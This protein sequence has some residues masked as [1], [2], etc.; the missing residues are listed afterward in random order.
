MSDL[1]VTPSGNGADLSWMRRVHRPDEMLHAPTQ[2]IETRNKQGQVLVR[3]PHGLCVRGDAACAARGAL[4]GVPGGATA[5]V[6]TWAVQTFFHTPGLKPLAPMS[7]DGFERWV[8]EA[9]APKIELCG[10]CGG[11]GVEPDA[12]PD[13]DGLIAACS[14]CHGE[15]RRVDEH[16]VAETV[17]PLRVVVADLRPFLAHL[18]PGADVG[19][20]YAPRVNIPGAL[21][22]H[23]RAMDLATRK[24]GAWRLCLMALDG[25]V[26]MSAGCG[27]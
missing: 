5:E 15:P 10:R 19:V 25:G 11:T 13:E 14:R 17:G 6:A 21:D 20:L 26:E 1:I 3:E 4:P 27:G 16:A 2:L 7:R 24:E 9:T 12:K 22:L 18:G 8:R 23:L